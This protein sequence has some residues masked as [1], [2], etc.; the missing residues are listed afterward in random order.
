[1]PV[2]LTEDL[3][4]LT[5]GGVEFVPFRLE[6][7]SLSCH[8]LPLL[9]RRGEAMP[10]SFRT[11]VLE[12]PFLK[13]TLLPDLGGRIIR[14]ED[15]RT[16]RDLL[17]WPPQLELLDG[18]HRGLWLKDGIRFFAGDSAQPARDLDLSAIEYQ[19][20]EPQEEDEPGMVILYELLPGGLASWQGGI[21]LYPDRAE[22]LIEFNL[23]NRSKNILPLDTGLAIGFEGELW[24]GGDEAIRITRRSGDGFWVKPEPSIGH[25][26]STDKGIRL[27]PRPNESPLMPREVF[28]WSLRFAPFSGLG[29]IKELSQSAGVGAREGQLVLQSASRCLGAEILLETKEGSFAAKADLHPETMFSADLAA[30]PPVVSLQLNNGVKLNWKASSAG[31]PETG[32]RPASASRPISLPPDSPEGRFA[33]DWSDEGSLPA[34]PASPAFIPAWR[35]ARAQ[36]FARLDKWEEADKEADQSLILNGEDYEAWW[37]KSVIRRRMGAG[38]RPELLNAHYLA[39]LEPLLRAE[40]YLQQGG[41]HEKQASPVTLRLA[42]NPDL[43]L[44]CIDALLEIGLVQEAAMLM[45]EILRHEDIGLVRLMLAW[46]LLTS[47]RMEVEAAQHIAMFEKAPLSPPLPSRKREVEAVKALA[48]RFPQSAGLAEMSQLANIRRQA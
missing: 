11:L 1:M 14:I 4:D 17:P 37:L 29:E 44:E 24:K 5:L 39:P 2:T 8:P 30:I 9:Q 21:T 19:I 22:F 42:K 23:L 12:N 27:R 38:E 47:S 18:S 13:L 46:S 10:R 33:S 45:D 41:S 20:R 26:E 31:G 16:S 32:S 40:G 34:F 35:L 3:L 7:P 28:S 6:S 43:G 48:A 36:A 25:G 15:K